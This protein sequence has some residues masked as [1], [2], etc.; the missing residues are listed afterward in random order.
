MSC[1]IWSTRITLL[2]M[3]MPASAITPRMATK[4]NAA[5]NMSSAAAAPMMP[6]GPVASTIMVLPK[7]CSWIMSSTRIDHQH[8]GIFSLME[9]W[10][11]AA[12][13]TAPCSSMR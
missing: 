8:D 3:M 6:S 4:P 1:S 11:L 12:S 10:L 2:R 7:C 13:S 5:W 9:V